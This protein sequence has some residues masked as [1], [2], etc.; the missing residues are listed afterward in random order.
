MTRFPLLLLFVYLLSACSKPDSLA[1]IEEAGTLQVVSRNS[2]TTY[3]MDKGSPTGFEF[4]L[5]QLFAAE[6]G[7]ELE[8]S[9]AFG[10]DDIFVALDRG[11]ADMAAAGLALTGERESHYPHGASYYQLRHS[12]FTW[13]APIGPGSLRTWDRCPL[14]YWPGPAMPI[15][16]KP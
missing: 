6:L 16:W 4:A 3:F 13:R 9:L 8:V 1:R 12:W 15:S 5:A 7:V 11:E 14:W 10:L 2:P